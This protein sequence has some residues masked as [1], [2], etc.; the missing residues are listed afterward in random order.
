MSEV[1]IE[2]IRGGWRNVP[3]HLKTK[4]QLSRMGLKP[5]CEP[6]AEVWSSH[7]WCKLYDIKDTKEKKKLTEKQLAGIKKAQI[8]R[9]KNEQLRWEEENKQ[10]EAA[11]RKYGHQTFGLWNEKDFVVLDTETTDLN[12]EIIEISI[13]DRNENVL[14]D[15]LVKPKNPISEEAYN[16]HGIS[17]NMVLNAPTWPEIFPVV[18]GILKDKLILVYN[19]EFD[20]QMIYNSCYLWGIEQPE[21][22]TECVMR[23][24]ACYYELERWVSLQNASGDYVNH[25]SLSDCFST[26]KV[27]KDVWVELGIFAKAL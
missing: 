5:T 2:V 23:T 15:S 8:T 3:E 9:Q 6:V 26:L 10:R 25:R 22:H 11:R 7:Q 13:I 20:C 24:Y 4:T 17:E 18:M 21:L 19:D 1:Q 27:I 12:G 16:I 14:F